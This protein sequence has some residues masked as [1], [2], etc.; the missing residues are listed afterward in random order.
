MAARRRIAGRRVRAHPIAIRYRAGG[1]AVCVE[2]RRRCGSC[3]TLRAAGKGSG[4]RACDFEEETTIMRFLAIFCLGV[5]LVSA[6]PVRLIFD[7]DMGN[8]VDDVIA[9][10]E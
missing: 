5:G 3:G 2:L 1:G 8:D 6:E 10:A 4:G 9:L 7:T